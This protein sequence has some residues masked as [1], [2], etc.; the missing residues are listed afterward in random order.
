M[1]KRRLFSALLI[2]ALAVA[3]FSPAL[4]GNG[5][6]QV[7][8]QN[9][10]PSAETGEMID[11]TPHLWFVEL[12][13]LPT[14]EGNTEGKI[15]SE[16]DA[17]RTQAKRLGVKYTEKASFSTLWNGFTV[18]A[19]AGD[20]NKLNRIP[21]VVGIFPVETIKIPETY[22][23]EPELFTSLAMIGADVVQSEL[24]FTGEGIKVAVMD[25]GIDVD[26]PAFGGDGVARSNSLLFPSARVPKGYDFVGDDFNAD[27][28][29][30]SYNPV[31]N[32]D[33]IPD[34]CYGH[35][36][37][38]AGIIGANDATNGMK[39][40]A[41][42]VTFGAYRVFG[43]EGSTTSDIMLMAME[44]AYR[45]RMNVLNMSIG[46]SFQWPQ[47]PTAKAA[48]RLVKKGMV[49][50]A[51]IGNSGA[52][53]LYSA[54]APG[55][56]ENVIGVAAFDNSHVLLPYFKVNGTPIGYIAM[57]YSGPVPTSGSAEIVYVGQACTADL[58]LLA[59]PA[60]KIALAVRGA[61]SFNEK[62]T[63]AIN[64][65]A[66]GV[67]I[68]NNTPGI[69]S[70]TLGS[71][72]DGVTPV[73]GI[74]QAD[75]LFI[76]SQAAPV[77]LT[78]TDQMAS[79]PSPTGGLISSFSSYGFAPDLSLKPDIGAPGGN[80]YSSYPIEKGGYATMSGTSMSSPHVAG[81]AALYL[82]AHP[83]TR[84]TDIRHIFQ[85]TAEPK[86]WWGYPGVGYLDNVTR[87]G[88]GMLRIDRA[89]LETTLVDPGKLSLGESAGGPVTKEIEIENH[90][91]KTVRYT[92]SYVNA[93][94]VVG[95]FAP[96]FW[97]SDAAVSF[98]KDT[99]KLYPRRETRIRVTVTPP[100]GPDQGQ[101]GGWIV[102]TGDDGSILR[103]PYAGFVGDYR[104]I[105]AITPTPNGFPWLAVS[106]GGAFY[107]PITGP[108]DWVYSM[109]GEDI[110]YLLIHFDHQVTKLVV[111]ILDADTGQPIHPYFN[112][113]IYEELLPRNSLST[114]FFA[115]G[116]DG[117]RIKS[118]GFHAKGYT[119]WN[120]RPVPDGEYILVV[121]ALKALGKPWNPADW[122]TWTS[123]VVAIDRP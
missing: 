63:N 61:C 53:G 2:A 19:K 20:V 103:V 21:G 29:S 23:A 91:D 32:P 15:R 40:V 11:E 22:E 55:V 78:W 100:S 108:E 98:S 112:T 14:I 71:P 41:P 43:C 24:G 105:Q 80:I 64:A 104:S 96:D 12:A 88:A 95:T 101:Y 113:A 9:P 39:G 68:F 58:P 114:S 4:A 16:Q 13:G 102:L 44:R 76:Q 97:L 33:P 70:G 36:T 30:P 73:V 89:I 77:T 49:V 115:F 31:P 48:S 35:G 118:N 87:Q 90:S 111:T 120:T 75:G 74:S 51:S 38:V 47:Y 7:F 18:S 26:H 86:D 121:K 79:F 85:N 57:T 92:L 60:G 122:E 27:E 82:D 83:R 69:F 42:D 119:K 3:G 46:A 8:P 94:S 52:Y 65:G 110:P 28:T 56:G 107:G 25:T 1:K 17:F 10:A 117:T 93:L 99:I 123:P 37:H 67:V 54:G 6:M 66:I 109:V 5:V 50:V 45:D 62:A 59:D 106:I 116:W 72:I 84:A 81:A 34:D